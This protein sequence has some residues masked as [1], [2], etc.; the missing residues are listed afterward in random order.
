MFGPEATT[1]V[2]LVNVRSREVIARGVEL[3]L[4]RATRR[5]GLL[6]RSGLDRDKA[7]V[8]APCF[9]VHTAFMRFPIDV[10][11]VDKAGYVRRIVRDLQPWRLAASASA[12]AT[13]EFAAG[14]LAASD[15][16]VGDRLCLGMAM[17]MRM[18]DHAPSVQASEPTSALN[19][20]DPSPNL[21]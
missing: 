8:L 1:A 20:V 12:Y 4:D 19:C 10:V 7:L 5:K 11:F 2:T 9:A 13:I 14:A 3:A 21:V 18:S 15:V 6:K 16:K 17:S